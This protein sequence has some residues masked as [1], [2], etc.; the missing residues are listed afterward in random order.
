MDFSGVPFASRTSAI[1]LCTSLCACA[2]RAAPATP[3]PAAKV[4]EALYP[5][6]PLVAEKPST[7]LIVERAAFGRV[8]HLDVKKPFWGA[9]PSRPPLSP[10][11]YERWHERRRA[12]V[13]FGYLSVVDL[14]PDEQFLL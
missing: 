11:R 5:S 6:T 1:I 14:T 7:P 3:G 2:S 4:T 9:A 12:R 10:Q 8:A 13:G